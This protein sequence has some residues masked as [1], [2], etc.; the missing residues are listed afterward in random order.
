MKTGREL[1]K[2]FR[3][4]VSLRQRLQAYRRQLD[5][6]SRGFCISWQYLNFPDTDMTTELQDEF[7]TT[8]PTQYDEKLQPTA[9]IIN[10]GL[11]SLMRNQTL[12]TYTQNYRRI[13][14]LASTLPAHVIFHDITYTQLS[15]L[16]PW[17]KHITPGRIHQ[18]NQALWSL[19]RNQS[20]LP[21]S[22]GTAPDPSRQAE[23]RR[24]AHHTWMER[25]L[26]HIHRSTGRLT[27]IPVS[28][29][30]EKFMGKMHVS[31]RRQQHNSQKAPFM[32]VQVNT[33]GDGMHMNNAFNHLVSLMDWNQ[34]MN[35][36]IY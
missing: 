36:E 6:D 26:C 11:H 7:T 21:P 17:K 14:H 24:R 4:K 22:S 30:T 25:N 8:D 18:W 5:P 9:V 2:V 3:D 35:T 31:S 12:N 16:P 13:L 20:C 19:F 10:G 28:Y 1:G 23:L 33:L 27:F 34:I 29:L 32:E 15:E